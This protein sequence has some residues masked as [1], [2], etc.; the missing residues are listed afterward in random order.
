MLYIRSI[1]EQSSVVWSSSITVDE[2]VALERVQ[3]CALRLIYQSEYI[4][5]CNALN[6]SGLTDLS[7][8]RQK[9]LQNF[10][11]KCVTNEATQFM[12]PSHESKY[13]TRQPEKYQVPTAL[14]SRS[15]NSP[16]I[17]MTKY[18]NEKAK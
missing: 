2:I 8:R 16:I 11:D 1:L 6:M 17:A 7:N 12:F 18:L 5:Y 15:K 4:S 3:K 14:H 9:L 10:A 13:N